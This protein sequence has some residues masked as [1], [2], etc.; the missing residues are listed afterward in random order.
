MQ[1][2]QTRL[3]QSWSL[4][5]QLKESKPDED[6]CWPT[7]EWKMLK[8]NVLSWIQKSSPNI[9]LSW[10]QKAIALKSSQL[11][12]WVHKNLVF[13]QDHLPNSLKSS[14]QLSYDS[15]RKQDLLCL[16]VYKLWVKNEIVN[17]NFGAEDVKLAIFNSLMLVLTNC[18]HISVFLYYD[19]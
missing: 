7:T 13:V 18:K 8:R 1:D 11:C 12:N 19:L 2:L 4:G 9:L 15:A 17:D 14:K 16:I 10:M 5:N 3:L 6:P